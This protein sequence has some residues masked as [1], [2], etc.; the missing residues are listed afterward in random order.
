MPYNISRRNRVVLDA[1]L[2]LYHRGAT[3]PLKRILAKTHA[4]D[5]A[6]ILD[7]LPDN[8]AVEIFHA[9]DDIHQ[10]ADA[11]SELEPELRDK[12]LRETPPADL[13]PIL[14]ELPPDDLT[15]L[16]A[17]QAP[18]LAARLM[19]GLDEDSQDEVNE[20][21]QYAPDT[22]GG[23]MTPDV[24]ALPG[25]M[26]VEE[27]VKAL[28]D[29]SEVEMVFYL[30]VVDSNQR[31]LGIISLRQLLLARPD[32]KLREIMNPRVISAQTGDDQEHVAHL[33]EQ[34]RIL[35]LPVV[36]EHDQLCGLITMDDIVEVIQD[37]TTEDML[38]MAGTDEAEMSTQ[39]PFKI[40]QLRLP[41]LFAAFLGGL[42]A[43]AV[44]HH[45]EGLLTRVLAL[46]F[47]LP[48]VMGMAGNVGTQSATVAVRSLAT[49]HLNLSHARG[50]I[51]KEFWVG[52]LLGV[53]YG[54]ALGLTS[55]WLFGDT[56]LG[57]IVGLT[58]LSNMTGAAV[59]A[60]IL[61]IVFH[62]VGA[63]PAIATGPFVT[64]A[65][66]ILGVSNYFL[67]ASLVLGAT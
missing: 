45:F 67:I 51:F 11:L 37:E 53:I 21:L 46:S 2:R 56:D 23:I 59:I 4:S 55:L 27:A 62:K 9:I 34:Y 39:S 6:Q 7:L 50:F 17:E 64:T 3:R 19:K 29:L 26:T 30:Y 63:D 1:I 61:P 57:V 13:F 20:L 66:D 38:K 54:L 10:A 24:F 65:I 33:V 15:D 52:L 36:D 12:I 14:H 8:E 48:I 58:I 44:I 35:A 42:A 31:L 40:V 28:R 22:A 49:G 18:D 5:L 43:T 41:W 47:F 16:I 25:D 32:Q 60:I